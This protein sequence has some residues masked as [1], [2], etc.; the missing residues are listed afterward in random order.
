MD[1]KTKELPSQTNDN[2]ECI[3]L[4][5][6][7][8]K[9]SM[10]RYILCYV[11]RKETELL[12]VFPSVP[13]Q[14]MEKEINN[15]SPDDRNNEAQL[16]KDIIFKASSHDINVQ[17]EGIKEVK[18]VASRE[19]NPPI[20]HLVALD[21][22]PIL[23]DCL[24][25]GD[26]EL[27]LEA[28]STLAII[29]SGSSEWAEKITAAFAIPQLIELL[30]SP[31]ESLREWVI[32]ILGHITE[33]GSK[34]AD[35]CFKERVLDHVLKSV[36]PVSSSSFIECVS[37]IVVSL[38]KHGHNTPSMES[39]E[40]IL[41]V[42]SSLLKR[43]DLDILFHSIS[44]ISSFSDLSNATH[45]KLIIG[46]GIIRQL[47]PFLSHDKN[48]LKGIALHAL[49]N[50]VT[51][52]DEQTQAVLDEDVL[53]YFSELLLSW[54]NEIVKD[55]LWFLSNICAGNIQQIQAVIDAGLIPSIINTMDKESQQNRK[56]AL[57]AI[58]NISE[59]GL[60]KQ[61]MFLVDNGVIPP[62]C[63]LLTLKNGN[64]VLTALKTVKNILNSSGNRQAYVVQEIKTCGGVVS[65]QLLDEHE[66]E[67][68]QELAFVIIDRIFHEKREEESMDLE[69]NY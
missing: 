17:L 28:I 11:S 29:A 53:K 33:A 23:F 7:I 16:L 36:T 60:T 62:L 69:D 59:N 57:F 2:N 44:I 12:I 25:K 55:A 3:G 39:L 43:K 56:W 46:S 50:I 19:F 13:T 10:S 41:S 63:H 51:G 21:I 15:L 18:N 22:I 30:S 45:M 67:D 38:W 65:L 26:E 1:Y 54:D 34:A 49:G 47:V 40:K 24:M 42:L 58:S 35:E 37:Q 61:I 68:V 64:V 52:N 8:Y 6:P 27:A 4:E 48:E 20:D 14:L 9:N 31:D 5:T 66:N 32:R